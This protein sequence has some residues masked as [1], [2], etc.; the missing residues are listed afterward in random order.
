MNALSYS[1]GIGKIPLMGETIGQN[2]RRIVEKH[3]DKEALIVVSQNYRATYSQF[4]QQIEDVARA[5]VAYDVK[6][7]DPRW[8]M[9]G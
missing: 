1:N 9:V 5:L 4:W 6:K 3:G 2:L 7:G 8:H